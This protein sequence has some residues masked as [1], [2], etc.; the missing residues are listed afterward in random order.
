[1]T[2]YVK[3]AC[4]KKGARVKVGKIL[5]KDED[6]NLKIRRKKIICWTCNFLRILEK[7]ATIFR[8]KNNIGWDGFN[9]VYMNDGYIDICLSSSTEIKFDVFVDYGVF[10]IVPH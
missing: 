4:N 8:G 3:R 5:I 2:L 7:K 1:M 10:S 6:W 9:V